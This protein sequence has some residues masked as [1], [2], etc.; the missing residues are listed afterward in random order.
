[1]NDVSV[2]AR[3]TLC[4]RNKSVSRASS[5]SLF[6]TSTA[7]RPAFRS[8][9]RFEEGLQT[10]AKLIRAFKHPLIES[11][12]LQYQ[13]TKFFFQIPHN[14]NELTKLSIAVQ[15]HFVVSPDVRHFSLQAQSPLES[16]H[17]NSRQSWQMAS[18][19]T[20]YRSQPC[21]IGSTLGRLGVTAGD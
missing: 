16:S 18:R 14:V 5:Q 10:T 1:M 6:R 11:R 8:A 20:S 13:R 17:T 9:A 19:R 3:A 12:K 7:N 15:Q 21:G 4:S 2:R